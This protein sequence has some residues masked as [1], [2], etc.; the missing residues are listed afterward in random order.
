MAARPTRAPPCS[1]GS[2]SAREEETSFL[3]AVVVMPVRVVPLALECVRAA[4]VGVVLLLSLVLV[5]E[6]Y[7]TVP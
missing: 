6:S 5:L 4:A 2:T 3:A 7:F 1:R